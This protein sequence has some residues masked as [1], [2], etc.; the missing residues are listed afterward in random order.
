MEFNVKLANLECFI[1]SYSPALKEFLKDYLVEETG[2]AKLELAVTKS[3][4][5]AEREADK[6]EEYSLQYLETLAVLRKLANRLPEYNRFLFHGAAITWKEKGFLFTAPSGTGK[7]THIALWRKYLGADVEIVNGDKPILEGKESEVQVYG[8]PWAGKE[9][10]QK[11]RSTR[12]D[13]LCI[14]EQAKE[15]EIRKLN[16]T[17]AVPRLLRQTYFPDDAKQAGKTLELLD[18]LLKNVPVYLLRCNISKEA[19]KCSFEA[20]TQISMSETKEENKGKGK[21]M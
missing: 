8:T 21:R 3:D 13:S 16:P 14:L 7:S 9:G 15:N 20:M 6:E 12:L 2:E 4:I 11:N 1:S 10:W 5:E 17:E 18:L 19:V